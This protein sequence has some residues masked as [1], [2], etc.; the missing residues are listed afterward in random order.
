MQVAVD[1]ELGFYQQMIDSITDYEVIR[2]DDTGNVR[3]WHEG[4][5]RLFGR[6]PLLHEGPHLGERLRPG[7]V[8]DERG[9]PR[10]PA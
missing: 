4:A 3:T 9:M 5:A 8:G 1:G 6:D 7:D 10:A 2:L